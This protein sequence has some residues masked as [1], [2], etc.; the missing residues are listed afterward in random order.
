M[1]NRFTPIVPGTDNSQQIATINNNFAQLDNESVKKLYYGADGV[2]R[3]YI[4]GTTGVIKVAPAGQD[5]TTAAD[6][7]LTFNSSQNVFKII[8]SGTLIINKP[9]STGS[10]SATAPHGLSFAPMVFAI[11]STG[12]AYQILPYTG[13]SNSGANSGKVTTQVTCY[14]TTTYVVA[15]INCPDWAG[16]ADYTNTASFTVKYYLLQ[17]SAA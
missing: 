7:V 17:E 16:N 1:P 3:V 14:T 6:G 9:A 12:T 11:Q 5:V 15:E 10:A 13:A 4:D 2:P 8:A